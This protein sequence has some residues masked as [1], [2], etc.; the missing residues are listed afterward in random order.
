M[1]VIFGWFFIKV[2]AIFMTATAIPSGWLSSTLFVPQCMIINNVVCGKEITRAFHK[3][4]ST[5]S[6]PIVSPNI[7][8]SSQSCCNRV[9]NYNDWCDRVLQKF[10]WNV[11]VSCHPSFCMRGTGNLQL[12]AWLFLVKLRTSLVII[13]VCVLCNFFGNK[14]T[15]LIFFMWKLIFVKRSSIS[16]SLLRSYLR[17][18]VHYKQ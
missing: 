16:T 17:P 5:Q 10:F 11:C 12:L 13:S 6:P 18:K 7:S 14:I 8:V 9:T 15:S 3:T 2:S 1:V 4:F